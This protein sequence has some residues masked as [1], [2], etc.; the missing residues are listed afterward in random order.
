MGVGATFAAINTMF[1]VVGTLDL[2]IMTLRAIGFDGHEVVAS[3]LITLTLTAV[4]AGGS[5][6]LALACLTVISTQ[7]ETPP[8][9]IGA[10]HRLRLHTWV[11]W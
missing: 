5:V 10:R 7:R 6:P 1:S 2:E 8:G 9:L 3:V 4:G 11:H